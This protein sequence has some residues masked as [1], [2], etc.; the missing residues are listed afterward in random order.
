MNP[1]VQNR[2]SNPGFTLIELLV[3]IAIIGVL[4]GLTLAV[5]AGVIASGKARQTADILKVLDQAASEV[6][7]ATEAPLPWY[8]AVPSQVG[9]NP[10]N[11]IPLID[12]VNRADTFQN[13]VQTKQEIP[14]VAWFIKH[15]SEYSPVPSAKAMI[16]SIDEKFKRNRLAT[17]G[18]VLQDL[19]TNPPGLR[20]DILDAWG[21]PIRMVHP[22]FDGTIPT[23]P[24]PVGNDGGPMG[25]TRDFLIAPDASTGTLVGFNYRR[26]YVSNADRKSRADANQPYMKGDSDGG[27][28]PN[29]TPYFYSGGPDGDPS[30][31]ADNVYSIRP[32]FGD[33]D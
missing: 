29:D 20:T 33:P 32:T 14:T 1:H 30:T 23:P 24:G 19:A 5:G 4:I 25:R 6:K 3:V 28:C 11:L 31:R 2:R 26:N 10:P 21:N 12:G 16:D 17:G 9:N 13:G 7:A 27:T 8:V 15:V 22:K 18:L